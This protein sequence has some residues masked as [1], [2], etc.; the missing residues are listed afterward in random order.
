MHHIWAP[1]HAVLD[2]AT[3]MSEGRIY[4]QNLRQDVNLGKKLAGAFVVNMFINPL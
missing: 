1:I 2:L 3:R 4:G